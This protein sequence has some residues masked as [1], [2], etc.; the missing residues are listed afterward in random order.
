MAILTIGVGLLST[1]VG[2]L[3]ALIIFGSIAT[4]IGVGIIAVP[5]ISEQKLTSISSLLWF[6]PGKAWHFPMLNTAKNA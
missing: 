1:I 6:K 5:N 3:P 2:L 4:L